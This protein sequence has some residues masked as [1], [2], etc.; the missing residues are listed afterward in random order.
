MFASPH[1]NTKLRS[2]R[3]ICAL[4]EL[5][6]LHS[7]GLFRGSNRSPFQ[8]RQSP[9][10]AVWAARSRVRHSV[11]TVTWA[12]GR[13]VGRVD[14]S[15]NPHCVWALTPHCQIG[16]LPQRLPPPC[17]GC[18]PPTCRWHGHAGCRHGMAVGGGQNLWYA[19]KFQNTDPF[20]K[21]MEESFR[22]AVLQG[23]G[24]R[25]RGEGGK[26]GSPVAVLFEPA[27]RF[28]RY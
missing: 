2:R 9:Y 18:Q 1:L 4:V 28:E 17:M 27:G 10:A 24:G 14:L 25:G 8:N 3:R 11:G 5:Q 23:A 13:K 7:R 21:G 26:K 12:G 19:G 6:P 20:V 16:V 22:P 15:E